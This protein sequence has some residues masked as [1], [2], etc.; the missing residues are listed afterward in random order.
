MIDGLIRTFLRTPIL[1]L[2]LAVAIAVFG[3]RA[4]EQNPKDAIPDIA[5]NQAIVFTEWMGR[6]PKDVDEQVT[7]PLTVALQGVPGVH[8]VRATSGFG[9]SIIYIVFD[10]DTGFYWARSRVLERL[11]VAQSTLPE[12]VRPVLGPDATAL[13][14]IF[15]YTIDNGWYCESHPGLRFDEDG[16]LLKSSRIAQLKSDASLEQRLDAAEPKHCPLDGKALLFSEIPLD[17]LRA[18]QD[19]DVKLALEGVSGVSE[20]ASVGG[21]VRQYQIDVNPDAMRAYNVNLAGLAKAVRESNVD[22]GA[23][24]IEQNGM[25]VLVRGIGFLG[26]GQRGVGSRQAREQATLRDIENIVV[27]AVDGTPIYVRQLGAV[28]TGPDFRRGALDKMGAEAVGASVIMRYGENPLDVIY[29]IKDILPDIEAGMPPG[30][31]INA[32][33]DRSG[34]IDE[35]MGTLVTALWQEVLITI[36]VV[37]LFLLHFRSSLVIAVTLPL[38]ILL[39]FICMQ[40]LDLGSNIMSLA[41]IAIAI[42]TMVDM[43]IVMT[44]NIYQHLTD[45]RDDFARIETGRDGRPRTIIDDATRSAVVTDAATEVGSA[46]LTAVSTTVVSFLPVFFLEGQSARLFTPLAWTKT[47]CLVASVLMALVLVPPFASYMLKSRRPSKRIALIVA[48][49]LAVGVGIGWHTLTASTTAFGSVGEP[50]RQYTGL[51]RPIDAILIALM[52]FVICW[53]TMREELRPI[54]RN[55]LSRWI[56]RIYEP[57]LRYLLHHKLM[58]LAMPVALVVWGLGIWLGWGAMLR[59]FIVA[60]DSIGISEWSLAWWIHLAAGILVG[61]F[62]LPLIFDSAVF[63]AARGKKS[64]HTSRRLSKLGGIVLGIALALLLHHLNVADRN[65][66]AAAAVFTAGDDN[67]VPSQYPLIRKLSEDARGIGQEFMPP[68]DEGDFLY[69]PSVLPAGSINTVMDVMRKQDIQF[70]TIPEVKTVVGKLGRVESA[71]DPAPIGMLE[72]VISLKPRSEWPLVD[73]PDNSDRKRRRTMDEIWSEIQRAGSFPGVL[74]SVQLQPIRTRVEMLSTGLNAKIGLKIYGDSIERCEEAAVAVESL[75]RRELDH[76]EAINA[77]RVNGKPYLEFHIDREAIARY[78]V[79]I[80]DVQNVIELA[81]GGM[82]LTTT[83]EGLDRYPVRIRYERELRDNIPDLERTLVSTP[84]GAQIPISLVAD[85]KTV[86]GPMSIRREGAKF[87]S[88]VTMSNVGVDETTLV[89]RGKSIIDKALIDGTL[90]LPEGI[91]KPKWTGSYERNLKAKRRLSLLVP[92]VLMINFVLIYLQFK[93]IPL[94][95]VVFLAI[96]V[97]FAGGFILLDFWPSIQNA[98]YAVGIM[99]RGFAGDE[100]YLTVAVWVGFIALF[101][102]AV[103]DGI[104]LGTYLDQTFSRRPIRQYDEIEQRVVDAGLR[105]IRPC[106]MTT[107]TT[108]AALVPVMISTGRGSDVMVPMAIPVFG[109]MLVE[110]ITLF[111]VPVCYCGLKQMKWR[112]GLPDQDFAR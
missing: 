71:L 53:V 60:L 3:W 96:P 14:Q 48:S 31:R 12:G 11:N 22:V 80:R 34:L 93:R 84:G 106:L 102:I 47:F 8:E 30:A 77:I 57:T 43:G 87:V 29:R 35:T 6:S 23:K 100:M 54:E 62:V 63:F 86:V 75:L 45:R 37:V 78:G 50:L 92:L 98:L 28:T 42:G 68:L 99:D 72:T 10:D 74:P 21:Y 82:N 9:W 15:W 61:G 67:I 52:C 16:T 26:G 90:K 41:G 107:F 40:A 44:E 7:Y 1:A 83:Y 46:I 88:Y 110:L 38:A 56:C 39:A 79:N 24:V 103:D 66:A 94:T 49:I 109:G 64:G 105:R 104:V 69:M 70:S 73:D 13:G 101:G 20:V 51:A 59:P 5:E 19:F 112:F 32:F 76:A 95:L 91:S 4:F 55:L 111:V 81:I 108:L 97:A 58:F 89:E 65:Q 36:I 25:E 17:Q 2:I 33:Y 18:M 27:K 85:I